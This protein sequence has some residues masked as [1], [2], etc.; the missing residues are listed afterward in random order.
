MAERTEHAQ[1]AY[2]ASGTVSQ[3]SGAASLEPSQ[4][5]FFLPMMSLWWREMVR[6][7][8]QRS[9]VIGMVATPLLFWL[10]I[11][12]GLGN[13]F[14]P[15]SPGGDGGY[16]QYFFPGTIVMMVL[17]TSVLAAMS[18][19]EDRHDGFLLS[20]M[21]APV[22]RAALVLGKVLGGTTQS[23]L[24]AVLALFIAPAVGFRLHPLQFLWLTAI[25]FMISFFLTSMGFY[26]AWKMDSTQGFH[27]ILN[28]VLMPMW[29]LSGAL[30]PASGASVAIQWTM[31]L[32]PLT[33]GLAAL[34]RLLAGTTIP[35]P[36]DVA[37]L[38]L[39]VE[40]TVLFTAIAIGAALIWTGRPTVKNLG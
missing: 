27:A 8:R 20:V 31:K 22:S 18:V 36:P 10:F 19:I 21:V 23:L 5:S 11:G 40:L 13:S 12:S 14:R 24:P 37:P 38:G 30:F 32:N 6:F 1:V 33:Y 9:R 35:V 16:L 4:S 34:R 39:S 25:L 7:T 3:H 29:L 26:I 2:P 28:L 17:F 15:Q